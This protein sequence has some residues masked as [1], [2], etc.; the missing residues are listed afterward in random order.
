MLVRM[1]ARSHLLAALAIAVGVVAGRAQQGPPRLTGIVEV[2]A[3]LNRLTS[4]GNA[5]AA[6]RPI[7]LRARPVLD[8][9]VVA[10]ITE[11]E[12]LEVAEYNYEESGA[13]AY[14][15]RM[16]WTLV[17]TSSGVV[18]WLSFTLPPSPSPFSPWNAIHG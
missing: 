15:R 8:G 2:P 14:A 5:I 10:T 7:E 3:L 18:G 13:V 17:K 16:E 6:E 4:D 9:A 12:Q 1:A 11:A